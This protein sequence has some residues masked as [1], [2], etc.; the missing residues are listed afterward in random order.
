MTSQIHPAIARLQRMNAPVVGAIHGV[1]AGGM[2]AFVAGFDLLVAAEEARFV[3][4]YAGI[5][6]SC[7]AGSSVMLTRRM[8]LSRARRYLL[9]N[10]TL[11]A[12][13]ALAAGLVDEVTPA[14]QLL[15]KAKG[16]AERLAAGPT[17]ALGE[18]KR[19]LLS[20]ADTALET[21]LELEAQALAR[22]SRSADAR[23]GIAA[24]AGKRKPA[25]VGR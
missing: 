8:G 1:C 10:E 2:A 18:T 15:D 11:D 23:E 6:F 5:G 22:V 9:L 7:D 16:F 12:K 24:F 13:S 4:A 19:L 14:A 17:L 3:A 25:F 21:Q 20:A